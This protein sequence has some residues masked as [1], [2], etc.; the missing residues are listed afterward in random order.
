MDQV[1]AS[2]RY[3]L[4]H[5]DQDLR[6]VMWRVGVQGEQVCFIF[7]ESNVLSPAFLE[8]SVSVSPV[9]TIGYT[10]LGSIPLPCHTT[11]SREYRQLALSVPKLR[12][13]VAV[14]GCCPR[15]DVDTV[16]YLVG[17]A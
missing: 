1:K 8:R 2:N 11:Y 3:T 5:F 13:G 14:V 16:L 4:E 9:A 12:Y 15:R 10:V 17:T 6:T 7:D